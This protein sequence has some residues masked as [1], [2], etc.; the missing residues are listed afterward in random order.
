[1]SRGPTTVFV[2]NIPYGVTEE[3]LLERLQEVG[4]VVNVRIVYDKDTGKPKG[5]GFCEYRDAETAESAVRNLNERIE[6]LGRTLRVAP[7]DP[8]GGGGGGSG[9]RS[10]VAADT[11]EAY[12]AGAGAARMTAAQTVQPFM[13]PSGG[14]SLSGLTLQQVYD[15]LAELKTLVQT[16]PDEVRAMLASHPP[17][18]HAVL[19]AQVLLGMVSV[20]Q[21][22]Q[23]LQA[24]MT[25]APP[26]TGMSVAPPPMAGMPRP[27]AMGGMPMPHTGMPGMPAAP[28]PSTA[29]PPAGMPTSG[30]VTEEALVRQLMSLTPAQIQA[31]PPDQRQQVM[32]LRQQLGQRR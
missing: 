9:G 14:S 28:P 26:A 2:G 21:A 22:Q 31:L 19:Q 17:I 5:F 24:M 29:A 6:L 11:N 16:N 7:S 3:M 20:Q 27:P 8:R 1:M 30:A 12:S 18:A 13:L 15:V 32:A 10:S 25:A 4:P 23:H